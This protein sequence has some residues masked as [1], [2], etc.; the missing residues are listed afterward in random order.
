MPDSWQKVFL[1]VSLLVSPEEIDIRIRRLSKRCLPS[2][3]QGGIGQSAG[4]LRAWVK[5]AEE[6]RLGGSVVQHLP[7]AQVMIL[8][9]WD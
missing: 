8:G 3:K 6:G 4:H 2:P 1:S 7:L 9:S 5:K